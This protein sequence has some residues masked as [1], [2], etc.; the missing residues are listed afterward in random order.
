MTKYYIAD[1][2]LGHEN[3]IE[4]CKRPFS[5]IQEM[6]NTLI[7]NWNKVVH[8]NDEVYIIGDMI[9]RLASD[10]IEYLERL[11]GKKHLILGNHDNYWVQNERDNN[12]IRSNK[13][14]KEVLEKYFVEITRLAVI[15]TG[16]GLASLCHYPMMYF[17]GKYLIH[18]HTHANSRKEFWQYIKNNPYML[19]AGV[20]INGYKP[21]TFDE[22]V[23]N[24]IKFKENH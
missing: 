14:S 7:D 1:M 18:G 2:H 4:M 11:K 5:S 23:E 17:E 9:Y 6:D 19:N 8:N 20:D 24:N 3:C 12:L 13:L 22:L 16:H 10:P 15:N 21:V